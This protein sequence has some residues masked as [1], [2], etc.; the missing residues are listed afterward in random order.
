MPFRNRPFKSATKP[1]ELRI[2]NYIRG[3][4][5]TIFGAAQ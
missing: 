4:I 1:F 5:E 3:P 2:S